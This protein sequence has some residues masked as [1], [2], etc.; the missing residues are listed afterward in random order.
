M[1]IRSARISY[2][3]YDTGS[4]GVGVIFPPRL[5]MAMGETTEALLAFSTNL[6]LT[7]EQAR[8]SFLSSFPFPAVLT[9]ES[10]FPLSVV[11]QI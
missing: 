6:Y 2:R 4:W 5:F 10:P 9:Y 3:I 11:F 8:C 1:R 7:G